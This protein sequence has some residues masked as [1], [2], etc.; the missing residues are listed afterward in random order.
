LVVSC[1]VGQ[2]VGGDDDQLGASA[3]EGLE[4]LARSL[5]EAVSQVVGLLYPIGIQRYLALDHSDYARP[6]VVVLERLRTRCKVEDLLDKAVVAAADARRD[7]GEAVERLVG[8]RRS[9]LPGD[10]RRGLTAMRH[11]EG[12]RH[13]GLSGAQVERLNGLVEGLDEHV[14]G[15]VASS[16]G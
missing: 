11:R 4:R 2:E 10:R 9:R 1:A 14:A 6:A 3:V 16:T 15:W 7:Q 8:P 5:G 13:H 12:D